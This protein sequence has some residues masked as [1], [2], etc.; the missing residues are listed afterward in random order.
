MGRQKA[1]RLG[2][3]DR[4]GTSSDTKGGIEGD[5]AD[6]KRSNDNDGPPDE[7]VNGYDDDDTP[8]TWGEVDSVCKT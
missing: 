8:L 3:G 5:D 2:Q 6:G 7:G 1:L 4:E